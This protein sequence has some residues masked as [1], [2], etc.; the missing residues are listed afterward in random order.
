MKIHE[1][2]A[3]AILQKYGVATAEGIV[4]GDAKE[5][6]EAWK[7][8][9]ASTVAMK[10]QIHAGG[11]GK[12]IL[13]NGPDP[14]SARR[15]QEGGVKIVR[16]P[17]EAEEIASRMFGNY[18]V[19]HQTGGLGKR[20]H[21]LYMEAGTE[22]AKEYYLGIVYDRSVNR[23]VLMASTEGGMDI[24][25]VAV[26][27]PHKIIRLVIE[28]TLGLQ[29]YQVRELIYRFQLPEEIHGEAVSF[30]N[31]IWNAFDGEDA[32][33]IEINPLALTKEARLIALDCKFI[34]DDNAAYRHPNMGDLRD[35]SEEDSLELQASGYNLNY[36]RLEGNVGCM[37]N[38]AGLAMATMDIVKL[39]GA[40]PANFL[41]VGGGASAE[42]V[43]NGFRI[44]LSDSHVKAIFV[45]IFGGIVQCDRVANGIVQAAKS[46][47]IS[48]PLIVRLRG[49]N[50]DL[51]RDILASSGLRIDVA[52]ELGEAATLVAKAVLG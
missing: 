3:K 44:I 26:K 18:L 52:D 42:T 49:T 28:P 41:D 33:V 4:I 2:Q 19:T 1:Y 11:R 27:M 5:V 13:Y 20:I 47:D 43:A 38:G 14:L 24:E 46:V 15:V 36:V 48:V 34:Y 21:R 32:S 50:A 39:A 6:A 31:G 10:A 22:I 8:L 29:P 40:A 12:G 25:E 7:K 45:N 16:S 17:I 37:V 23:P 9:G 51:A 35:I 30:F